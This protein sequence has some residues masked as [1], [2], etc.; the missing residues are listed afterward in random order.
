MAGGAGGDPLAVQELLAQLPGGRRPDVLGMRREA[1]RAT[2]QRGGIARDRRRRVRIVGVDDADI[3]RHL[4]GQHQGLAEAADPVGGTIAP[5]VRKPRGPG[6]RGSVACAASATRRAARAAAPGTD[7]PADRARAPRSRDAARARRDRS[8]GAATR[9]AAPRP[10]R[11]SASSSCAM[12]VSDRRGQPLTT[13]AMRCGPMRPP[14]APAQLLARSS[15]LVRA[16]G[17]GAKSGLDEC[18]AAP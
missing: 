3:R 11:S 16:G 8:G 6:S 18:P 17:D 12:K 2:G 15:S 5:Q 1:P 14:V 10:R 7:T 4:G 13:T 9:S